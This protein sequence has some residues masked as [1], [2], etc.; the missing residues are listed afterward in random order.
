[1]VRLLSV[2]FIGLLMAGCIP[3]YVDQAPVAKVQPTLQLPQESSRSF[4]VT[5]KTKK[6]A[7]SDTGFLIKD[8]KMT[9]LN[10]LAA[11]QP[12]LK[13]HVY[14][15]DKICVNS[16]CNTKEGFNFAFLNSAYPDDLVENVLHQRPI[17]SG[18]NLVQNETG[19]TQEIKSKKYNIKYQVT[20]ESIY[21]KD[22]QNKI[23][24]KL[25][26]LEK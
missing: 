24:M 12:V 15:E 10:V 7:F 2:L 21:F 9:K 22:T 11:G 20:K 1:M 3:K 4:M 23:I 17:F 18:K 6:F 5:M 19:F 14:T 16:V 26:E 13:M 8:P 25:K